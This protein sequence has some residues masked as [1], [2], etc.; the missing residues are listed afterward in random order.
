MLL[1]ILYIMLYF[2]KERRKISL[3]AIAIN[4]LEPLVK[5]SFTVAEEP[6]DRV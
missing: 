5:D 1:Y 4:P 3:K 2:G 6:C